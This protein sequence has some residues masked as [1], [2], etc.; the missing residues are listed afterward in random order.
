V[1]LRDGISSGDADLETA[2]ATFSL[3]EVDALEAAHAA[4]IG[5]FRARR[6]AAFTAERERWVQAR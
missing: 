4:E 6:R 1:D 5:A 2:P 3:A